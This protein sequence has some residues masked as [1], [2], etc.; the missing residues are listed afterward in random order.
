MIWA[1]KAC[2]WPVLAHSRVLVLSL[3]TIPRALSQLSLL[4][5]TYAWIFFMYG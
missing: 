4:Q 3:K 1:S 2:I 5:G